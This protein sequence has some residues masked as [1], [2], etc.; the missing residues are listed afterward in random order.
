M[1]RNASGTY[2]LPTGNPVVSGT[3]ITVTWGNNTMNDIATEMTDSL[4]RSGKGG[5]LAPLTFVDG[6]VTVPGISWVSDAN[7]GFYRIGADNMAMTAGGVQIVD[8]ANNAF[9]FSGTTDTA[10]TGPIFS[11]F[12]NSASPAD[13]DLIGDLRFDGEDSAGNKTTYASVSSQIDDV[14]N[15]T[16]DGTLLVKTMTAGTLT[17]Q[18]DIS[19]ALVNI[20]PATTIAGLTTIASLK[21]TGAVTITDILD[22][23]NMASNSATKLATQQSIKA[24]VDSSVGAYDTLSEVLAN[25]NTSGSTDLVMTSG[26]KITTNTIDETTSA[27][28]VTI[29][30]VLVKDSTVKAGTLTIGAGSIT[31]S[32]GA[33]T[34]GNENL[35]TTGNVDANGVEFDSLSGTGAVAITDIKDEDNMASN[36]ATMLAT[37]QS[38]K[39]YVDA[40]V[41]TVDTLSEVLAI[42]NTSGSTDLVMTSGQK[43]TT[44]TIDETTA[45][46]GVTIDSVLVKDSTVKAGT[47]TIGGG[48][49]TDSSGGITFGNENL[50]TTGTLG[51]G[52]LTATTG[53]FSGSVGIGTSSPLSNRRA[54]F[55]NTSAGSTRSAIYLEGAYSSTNDS[56][57]IDFGSSNGTAIAAIRQV[58]TNTGNGASDIV[59]YTWSGSALTE[60]MRLKSD[61]S[62][63]FAGDI[64]TTT[65]GTSNFRAGANAGNS[66]TSGG[67]YNTVVGDEAGTAI[68][69]GDNNTAFGK[70]ALA[71]VTTAGDNTAVGNAALRENTSGES[72]TAVGKSALI[73]NTVANRNVA[74]GRNSL[75]AVNQASATNTYNV[76]MGYDSGKA[77]TTGFENTLIGG[78]AGGALTDADYNLA[79]G[80]QALANDTL[81]SRSTAI[82]RSALQNQNFTGATNTYNTAVGFNAGLSMTTG[83]NNTI[84]G[85]LAGDTLTEGDRNVAIGVQALTADTKGN[86]N[87]AIGDAALRTQNFTSSTDAYNVA[88]GHNAGQSVTTGTANTLM[89]GLAGDVLTDADYNVAMG[90]LALST[91]TLGSRSTAIGYASLYTQNFTSATN[92]ENTAVGYAAGAV[93]TTGTLNTLIGS[94]AGDGL[95]DAHYNTAV[96]YDALG[97]NTEANY[98]TAIGYRALSVQTQPSSAN[99]LNTAVGADAGLRVTGASNTTLLGANAGNHITSGSNNT[100]IGNS[101]GAIVTNGVDNIC[102]GSTSNTHN[103]GSQNCIT[104]G[105]GIATGENDQFR[106]GKAS[107]TVS[108]EFDTDAAW[109][110]ASDERL[111]ENIAADTLG[112]D[113]IKN[114]RPV[115]YTW[116]SSQDLDSSD[117][118]LANLYNADENLMNT[119]VTMHGL[120][121]QEVKSA[122]DT[123]GV[124]TFSGWGL[125]EDGVQQVSRE[126]FVIPLIKAIQE[127]ND[128][129]ESLTARITALES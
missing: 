99:T 117:A 27:S 59:S 7:T 66:I 90:Y 12:R 115:T 37:Q 10:A 79:V 61:N 30:S 91:D 122:L 65:A 15:A 110:R 74:V 60:A 129:I 101:A 8:Y 67:N 45:A 23:D 40:Q 83:I 34:F 24:Y 119:D 22:E 29:D 128:L 48:T 53:T 3:D 57:G 82:G 114:L 77:V 93:L 80:Y 17:T 13:A 31:D 121:A 16:E 89:G 63:T 87:I 109:T 108:N 2:T 107:N 73:T 58:M 76:A 49:I 126:M 32:S 85:G 21:G 78:F 56:T 11:I 84:V 72:N 9:T 116:K 51:S 124:T 35:T 94:R 54:T 4:S 20:T 86:K 127:Q 41:D 6:S 105:V 68:T 44:N 111:K 5:M 18:L 100:C 88:V 52:A 120:I 36:S 14:T 97:T 38:I 102:I 123:E 81:G 43:V 1:S 103:S 96:G 39:A 75:S 19:S 112:L 25:G 118:Q 106:F 26:Q 62:A 47:L 98:N 95:V 55:V 113:F 46:S 70:S 92:A 50:V 71:T 33:I 28:G 104:L 125:N 69:T 42:G 64:I